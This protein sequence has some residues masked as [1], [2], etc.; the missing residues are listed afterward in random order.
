M[1]NSAEMTKQGEMK[2]YDKNKKQV[3]NN[4]SK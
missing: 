1:I 2:K 3:G 4:K